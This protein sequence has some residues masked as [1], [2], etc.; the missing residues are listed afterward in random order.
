MRTAAAQAIENRF[1][2]V[3]DAPIR[4]V[5]Q[6]LAGNPFVPV[7]FHVGRIGQKGLLHKDVEGMQPVGGRML[8]V[9]L[10]P[11]TA[12]LRRDLMQRA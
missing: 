8:L 1:V 7:F 9:T 3:N 2:T 5:R 11:F 6:Q 10:K 12:Q 4:V